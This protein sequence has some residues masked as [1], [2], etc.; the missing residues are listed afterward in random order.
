MMKK[1][2]DVM[3]TNVKNDAMKEIQEMTITE[4]EVNPEFPVNTFAVKKC[5]VKSG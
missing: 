4:F 2:V 3:D 1:V 5:L